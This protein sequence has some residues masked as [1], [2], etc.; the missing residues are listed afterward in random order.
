[1]TAFHTRGVCDCKVAS[2]GSQP[3]RLAPCRQTSNQKALPVLA[4]SHERDDVLQILLREQV[5][6]EASPSSYL[7][8]APLPQHQSS[9][10]TQVMDYCKLT[11]LE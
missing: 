4:S 2:C 11:V 1:M 5:V 3:S 7:A 9:Q 8:V 6:A 10:P